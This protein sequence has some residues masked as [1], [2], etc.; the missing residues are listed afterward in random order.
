MFENHTNGVTY[1]LS[2]SAQ[3]EYDKM[4]DSFAEFLDEKYKENDKNNEDDKENIP[5]TEIDFCM[6]SSKDTIHVLRLAALLHILSKYILS[7]RKEEEND[8]NETTI[9]LNIFNSARR[10]YSILAF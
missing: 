3:E 4:T 9:D 5:P 1:S 6:T 7:Q 10:L 2:A 8:S